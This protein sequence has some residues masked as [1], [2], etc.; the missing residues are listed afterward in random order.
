MAAKGYE[1]YNTILSFTRY[2]NEKCYIG[3]DDYMQDLMGEEEYQ[4]F[5]A[6]GSW[7]YFT[8]PFVIIPAD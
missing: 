3:M 8:F 7:Y 1:T 2:V 5:K 4:E 6:L